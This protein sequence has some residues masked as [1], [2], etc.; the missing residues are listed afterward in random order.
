[1]RRTHL[2]QHPLH[3]CVVRGAHRADFAV[4]IRLLREPF[5][6]IVPV[7]GVSGILHGEGHEFTVRGIAP[8]RVL[9]SDHVSPRARIAQV[10]LWPFRKACVPT[11]PETYRPYPGE[12]R[13]RAGSPH[14][15]SK[16][17]PLSPRGFQAHHVLLLSLS[18]L[19]YPQRK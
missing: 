13:S 17:E 9:R 10:R 2:R 19:S 16:R 8:A 5:D 7:F 4:A 3:P 11:T 12:T 14:P 1:M 15:A 18:L 6:G